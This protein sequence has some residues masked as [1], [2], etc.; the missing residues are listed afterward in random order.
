MPVLYILSR[1]GGGNMTDLFYAYRVQTPD[2]KI[3]A[4]LI[5]ST[6]PDNI[7]DPVNAQDEQP[8]TVIISADEAIDE[9]SINLQ[10]S[11]NP[12]M[13]ISIHGFIHV[14]LY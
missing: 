6:A 4:Y 9:I 1:H 2:T 10:K 12:T 8:N 14:K 5:E 13:V 7:D 11:D 3:H